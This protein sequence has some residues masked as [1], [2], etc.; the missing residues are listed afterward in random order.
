MEDELAV[1]FEAAFSPTPGAHP[2]PTAS[3]STRARSTRTTPGPT[4]SD[5]DPVTANIMG[6]QIT[7]DANR[8]NRVRKA[9]RHEHKTTCAQCKR[10]P[11]KGEKLSMCSRC[12]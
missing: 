11:G 7:E 1:A 2:V 3:T 5:W 4:R 8:E 10:T 6:Q 12:K 9:R